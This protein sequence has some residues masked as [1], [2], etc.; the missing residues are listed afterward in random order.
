MQIDA[1]QDGQVTLSTFKNKYWPKCRTTERIKQ[2][3]Q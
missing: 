2:L 3:E 1:K